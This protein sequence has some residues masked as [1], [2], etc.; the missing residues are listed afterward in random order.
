LDI[1]DEQDVYAAIFVSEVLASPLPDSADELVSELFS[2]DIHHTWPDP[3]R[4]PADGVQE[5]SLPQP[6]AAVNEQRVIAI[7]GIL[8]YSQ[9]GGMGQAIA[10]AHYKGRESIPSI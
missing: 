3:Y 8:R 1:I 10:A 7:S 2:G 9:G 4:L 5:V 6:R